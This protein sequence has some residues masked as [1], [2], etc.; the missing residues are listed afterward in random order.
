MSKS[1][2]IERPVA[3]LAFSILE[4]AAAIGLSRATVYRLI[5]D[6]R[7]RTTKVGSRRLVPRD[8]IDALLAAA[9]DAA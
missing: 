9:Q 2:K 5:G 4:T 7:L 1:T 6:G 3:P 8:A